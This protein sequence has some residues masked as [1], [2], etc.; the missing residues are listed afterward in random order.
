MKNLVKLF[1]IVLIGIICTAWV[2]PKEKITVY[3]IGDSTCADKPLDDNPERGW[4]QVFYNFFNSDIVIENH[5]VNGRSTKSF[6]AEGR[7]QKIVDQ[8]K[9]GNFVF[10]QFGHNDSKLAD[11]SRYSEANTD[12]KK[13]L[14]RYIEESRSKNALPVLLTPVNRRKF[15][16]N[17]LFIDQHGDYPKVV[18]EVAKEYNVPLI[19]VHQKSLELFTKLGVEG[20][21]K[22]FLISVKPNTFKF[23]PN[24]KDDNTHFTREGA[25]EVAKLVVEG[26][27]EA[28]LP[29][30]EYLKTDL[31]F[32]NIADGKLVALDYF[33]NREFKKDKNGK[34]V[35]YH[36]TWED[37]ENSGY[38]E[39]GNMI[40]NFG[41]GIY[42]LPSFPN[43]DELKKISVYIIVDPD[44]QKE[45][46][47]PNYMSDSAAAEIEKWVKEGGVLALFTNDAGNCEFENFNKLSDRFGIH[48]NENSRNKLTGTEFYKG[49]FDKLPE[50]PIF[51]GV[52]AVYLK[53]ISTLKL[54][55][56]AEPILIDGEDV[57]MACSKV[58]N[59]FVFAVGDPWIYN[60]YFDNRKL[61]LEFENYKAA[62]NLF[63]WLL[64]KAKRVR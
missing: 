19:D 17:G 29:I 25:V 10:I 32:S 6:R 16:G 56:P 38:Y 30:A 3:L 41:A 52:N 58:G 61:P 59:G 28:K 51:K 39:L 36:Y 47:A 24:G 62:K 4:G 7:W 8:L 57:I 63:T 2:V 12:Y 49:K 35:Q 46:A 55:A 60:E 50:H 53:E 40:E 34:E 42:E 9:P 33:F 20:T 23:L 27:K 22:L 31:P 64:E 54:S 26:I 48:F 15:D 37:K 5:A 13:N 18:R 45:T 1:I 14:I 21:K 43:Y 11:T 44:T